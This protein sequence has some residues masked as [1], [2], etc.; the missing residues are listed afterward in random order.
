M[1]YEIPK[2]V[3]SLICGAVSLAAMQYHFVKLSA[4]NTVVVCSGVTDVPV[5]VL[6]N[7]PGIGEAAEVLVFGI[8]KLVVGGAGDLTFGLAVGTDADGHAVSS[9]VTDTT[10]YNVG[11]V[12]EGAGSVASC[13]ASI[14]CLNPVRNA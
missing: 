12:L 13:V 8:S 5:G 1:A 4:D 9:L 10:C 14:N 3:L 11:R 2:K 6:Q 7:D